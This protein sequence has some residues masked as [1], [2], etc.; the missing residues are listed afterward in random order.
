MKPTNAILLSILILFQSCYSYKKVD[1][2]NLKI[3]TSKK[4]VIKTSKG[5]LD[6]GKIVKITNNTITLQKGKNL[7]V[8]P[9]NYIKE[10]KV[11]KHSNSNTENILG[12]IGLVVVLIIFKKLLE[13][14]DINIKN[15]TICKNGCHY[16]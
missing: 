13:S 10:I 15:T 6:K 7:V 3:D 14:I 4:Y 9:K 16:K 12:A 2:Q 11:Q 8:I 5:Q 1:L